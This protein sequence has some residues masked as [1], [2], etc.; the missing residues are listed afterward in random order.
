M[1]L[2]L[3]QQIG[4]MLISGFKGLEV[5][6]GDP[7]V[8]DII[9]YNLGG[10]ILYDED[11][12][13]PK[14]RWRNIQTP[15]QTKMLIQSLQEITEI[16]LLIGVD[17]EGGNVN[18]L[19]EEYGFPPCPS[20]GEIGSYNN[21]FKTGDFS[22]LIAVTLKNTGF[23]MNFAPVLDVIAH[24][25]SYVSKWDRCIGS[26]PNTIFDHASIFITEHEKYGIATT[27]KH[28]PG[29]GSSV[30]D[31]HEGFADI[32]DTWTEKELEP[33]KLLF[34][35][36]DLTL[37]MVGHCFHSGIDPDWPA[38]MSYKTVTDLLRKEMGFEGVIICDDPLMGAIIENYSFETAMGK[39]IN[40]GV[41]LIC[42]GNNLNFDKDIVPKSVE[43]IYRLIKSGKI[44]EKRIANSNERIQSLKAKLQ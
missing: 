12:S 22:E 6:Q 5:K 14:E 8:R 29:L 17:Q 2:S 34:D 3:K 13:N 36:Y 21:I 30:A 11:V 40:A 44:D 4:Q 9:E 43:T 16:P 28:F 10:V 37:V 42:F 20:W 26:D 15:E 23:N 33:Y 35:H 1:S 32:T 41:D 31:T 27:C 24:G 38:S 18:R 7:V 25:E 19:K 39:I